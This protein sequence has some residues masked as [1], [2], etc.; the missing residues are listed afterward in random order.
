[1]RKATDI[2]PLSEFISLQR[3]CQS[4]KHG[5]PA[6]KDRVTVAVYDT[7]KGFQTIAIRISE[8]VAEKYGLVEGQ[9]MSCFVHP[10]QQHIALTPGKGASLFRPKSGRALVY[11]TSVRRNTLEPQPATEAKMSRRDGAFVISIT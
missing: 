5:F 4:E 3:R 9:K 6:M 11:Q 10:D 7:R 8:D 1:M 2:P